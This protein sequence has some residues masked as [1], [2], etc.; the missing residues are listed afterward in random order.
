MPSF[1]N[2]LDKSSVYIRKGDQ[3]MKI[4]YKILKIRVVP[5]L[6]PE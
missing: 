5:V 1:E 6:T 2:N 3:K 4:D